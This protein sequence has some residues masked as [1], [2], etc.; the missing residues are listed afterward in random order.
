M[1]LNNQSTEVY[2]EKDGDCVYPDGEQCCC[3]ECEYG[4][5][6]CEGKLF[7]PKQALK[8]ERE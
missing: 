6:I 2:L 4:S 7:K 3:A 8:G 5:V 1:T